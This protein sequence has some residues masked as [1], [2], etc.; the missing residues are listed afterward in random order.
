MQDIKLVGEHWQDNLSG[1][2]WSKSLEKA[3]HEKHLTELQLLKSEDTIRKIRSNKFE[4][5]ANSLTESTIVAVLK[6]SEKPKIESIGFNQF[7]D[8]FTDNFGVLLS[9]CFSA[10]N[11]PPV[12][13]FQMIDASNANRV[14]G[15]AAYQ[16][17]VGNQQSTFNAYPVTGTMFRFGSGSTAAARGNYSVQTPLA[18]TPENT[19]FSSGQGSYAGTVVAV[20]SAI[21]AGG[22]GNIQEVGLFGYFAY[23]STTHAYFMLTHDVLNSPQSFVQGN[24]LVASMTIQT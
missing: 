22:S 10:P 7:D 20:A 1:L 4:L 21:P 24:P 17:S 18:T 14:F 12:N 5:L 23:Q 13:V 19:Y 2:Q 6:S 15:V 9:M 16:N 8:L 3:I 11:A